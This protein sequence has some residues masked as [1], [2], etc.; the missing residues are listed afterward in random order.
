MIR[1]E[2]ALMATAI[3]VT[4]ALVGYAPPATSAAGPVSLSRELGPARL[5]LT[6][7]PAR[8]G[9]NEIHLYLFDRRSGAQYDKPKEL[10]CPATQR[11]RGSAPW[12]CGPQDRPRPLLDPGG[13]PGPGG[14]WTPKV[15]ALVSQFDQYSTRL[16]VPIR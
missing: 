9:R 8:V 4:A 2:L 14:D 13:R 10:T 5:E 12:G 11:Q 6:V 15:D 7:S 3:A 16:E 1:G